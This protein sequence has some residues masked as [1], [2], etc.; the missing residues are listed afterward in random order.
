MP[1]PLSIL[2][3]LTLSMPTMGSAQF[4]A[5]NI[6]FTRVRE[7][8]TIPGDY[9]LEAEIWVMASDGTKAR[10][11]T[12]N[13]SD[14]Y[15]TAWSPDGKTLIF[16]AVQFEPNDSGALV[17]ASAYLYSV[18]ADGGEPKRISPVGMRAQFPSL[19]PDGSKIVFH[20]GHG[21]L[22]GA[23][24]IFVM[25]RDGTDV[26]Q[27]TS[28]AYNDIRPDWSPDG[29]KIAF[30]SNRDGSIQIFVMNVDGSDVVQLTK[31]DGGSNNR[32]PAYSPDGKRIVFVSNR[33]GDPE[34]YVMNSDGSG[35]VRITRNAGEDA[36]PEWSSDGTRII[37]DRDVPVRNKV[38]PQ[39]Y[40]MNPD[41]SDVRPLTSLPSSNSHA[42]WSPILVK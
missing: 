3:L 21:R 20:G 6:A 22:Q 42:A 31:S 24:E 30:T 19:S 39:L 35:Q 37:F 28:N 10:R 15:G 4:P 13:T 41:G 40:L 38:V 23:A 12:R 7:D 2:L 9:R 11:I 32:A 17:P 29:K 14:D 1:A 8:A 33:D 5:G 36:D 27:L 26:Q 34:I 25:N 18:D 16:G